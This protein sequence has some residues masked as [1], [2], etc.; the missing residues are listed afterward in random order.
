M[1][2]L[3][4]I[5]LFV[6]IIVFSLLQT[7]ILPVNS[8]LL[9]VILVSLIN[10]EFSFYFAFLAGLILDLARGERW[11]I[12]PAV[13]LIIAGAVFLIRRAFSFSQERRLRLPL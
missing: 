5:S 4:K 2:M 10:G 13:F 9:L 12:S 8:V 11:G 3:N 1:T 7:T 6:L